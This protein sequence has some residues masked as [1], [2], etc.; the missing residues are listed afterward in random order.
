MMGDLSA[1]VIPLLPAFLCLW[2][3]RERLNVYEA[4]CDGAAEGLRVLLRIFPHLLVLLTAVAMLRQSGALD[5]LASW[6]RPA[7]DAVGLPAEVLPL[8]LLRPFSGSGAL[9]VGSELI[10]AH[11]PDSV[12]GRTAAVM[13]GCTETTFYT[14]TVYFGAAGIKRLR[15]TLPA[16]LTADLVGFL[17]AAWSV[18][19]LF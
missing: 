17:A 11:G 4:L 16:A 15:H 14:V 10:A 18:R 8:M 12:A 9:A 19:R 3:L 6:L 13:L 5:A 1:V 2:A 7:L